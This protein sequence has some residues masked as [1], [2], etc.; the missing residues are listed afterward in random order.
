M[1]AAIAAMVNLRLACSRCAPSL[2]VCVLLNV[3]FLQKYR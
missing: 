3:S 1:L 2:A